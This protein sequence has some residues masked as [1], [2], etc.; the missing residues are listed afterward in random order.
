MLT[1]NVFYV[2][3]LPFLI[4]IVFFGCKK[5]TCEGRMDLKTLSYVYSHPDTPP[6]MK[7]DIEVVL[8][9]IF[10]KADFS[11][12]EA[13]QSTFLL[14]FVINTEGQIIQTSIKGKR[15]SHL[16][17]FERQLLNLVKNNTTWKPAI[18]NGKPVAAYFLLPI[19][20]K[21]E[22]PGIE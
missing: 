16:S 10:K 9:L 14:E 11:L 22:E 18:C 4:V 13:Y 5:Q 19:R 15:K 3:H 8:E 1:S 12:N 2:Y 17:Y 21:P 6:Q 7:E 20:F